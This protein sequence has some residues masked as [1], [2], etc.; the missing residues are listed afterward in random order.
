MLTSPQVRNIVIQFSTFVKCIFPIFS[1][2]FCAICAI[3]LLFSCL[4]QQKASFSFCR[5]KSIYLPI[6]MAKKLNLTVSL[7][8]RV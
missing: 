3:L 8:Y 2:I 5:A 4:T 1:I 6:E 7:H